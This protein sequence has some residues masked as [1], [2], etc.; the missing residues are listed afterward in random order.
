LGKEKEDTKI[1]FVCKAFEFSAR[2]PDRQRYLGWTSH[3]AWL[4]EQFCITS[5]GRG[6]LW[7]S[8]RFQT[9]EWIHNGSDLG[10]TALKNRK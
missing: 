5:F 9:K 7:E 10:E 4:E 8:V 3:V 1:S 6:D 2:H